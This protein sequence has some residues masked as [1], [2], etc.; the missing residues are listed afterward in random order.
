VGASGAGGQRARPVSQGYKVVGKIGKEGTG[1][2]Q[3]STNV[4]GMTTDKGGNVYVT[5]SNLRRIQEFSAKGAYKAK[6]QF[7]PGLS[8]VDVAVGPTGDVWGTT[9]VNKQVRRFPAGGGAPE[10]LTTPKSAEGIAVDAEGNVY[11]GTTGDNIHEVVRF[12]KTPT[13]WSGAN[14]WARAHWPR[15]VKGVP[16][17]SIY[18]GDRR[19]SP[20]SI[21]RYDATGKLQGTIKTGHPATA[22]A[23]DP[24]NFGVDPDC[25]LWVTNGGQRRVDRFSP[26]GKLL[27]SVTSGDLLSTDVAV[28]PTGDLYVFDVNTRSVFHF[29]EDK[30]KPGT[31][32]VPGKIAVNKGKATVK[33]VASGFACPAQVDAA[34][35]LKGA[36][37]AGAGKGKVVAGK[38]NSLAMTVKG[39]AG[40]TVPAT[41]TI[42]LKTNGRT[43]TEKKSVKVSF[44]K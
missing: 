10:N 38:A 13:R 3:F 15:D 28:G 16:D 18:V 30:S 6:W 23:G 12:G 21:R 26:S 17:G 20:P 19:G 2:G 44:A 32:N 14:T 39:P 1:N 27:G 33:Y 37:V 36:G 29:A 41:F 7:E 11:V 25:N 43:T 24:Y 35:T 4:F 8:L 22:G 31:A 9:Q 34:F 5:D 40:K 42:V